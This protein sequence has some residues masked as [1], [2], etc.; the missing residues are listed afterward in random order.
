MML[1]TLFRRFILATALAASASLAIPSARAADGRN[2]LEKAAIAV[3]RSDAAEADKALA[4]KQI[5]I[6]GS[7]D[8]VPDLAALLDNEKLHSWARTGLEAIP[9]PEADGALRAAAATLSGNLLVGTINSLGVR[10]DAGALAVLTQRLA[11]R[12]PDV[13]SAAAV[14]LGHLGT[15]P[16]ISA[17]KSALPRANGAVQS[18]IAEGCIYAAEELL[19]AGKA[20]DA[21]ALYDEV[22]KAP[23]PAQRKLE[24]TR[25]AILA[26]GD[27]AAPLLIEQLQ[28]PEQSLFRLGLTTAREVKQGKCDAALVAEL[29]KLPAARAALLL[30]ALADR[31][32]PAAVEALIAAAGKGG[33]ETRLA[34][35]ESL[36]A[37]GNAKALAVL[38]EGAVD[39]DADLARAATASISSLSGTE[40]NSEIKKRLSNAQGKLLPML[41]ELVGQ[42]RIDAIPP[43]LAAVDSQ[44]PA[45]R[46][47]ALA[48]LGNIVDVER[49]PVLVS[50]VVKPRDETD[51]ANAKKALLTAAIRMPDRE[52]C[53]SAVVAPLS[54]A[55]AAAKQVLLETLGAV[56]GTKA[57]T[58]VAAA[59]KNGDDAQKDVASRLLGEW[60]T[61]DAAPVLLDLSKTLAEDKYRGRAIRGFIRIARQFKLEQSER[62]KMALE[63]FSAAKT[64][65]EKKLVLEVARRYPD[66]EMLKLAA[67]A[68]AD[69]E[70]K[71]ESRIAAAA[72][73]KKLPEESAEAYALAKGLGLEKVS[74]EIVKATYGSGD[75]QKDVTD[76]V[77]KN[78]GSLPLIYIAGNGFN[79]VF[80]GDPAPSAVKHLVIQYTIDGQPGEA[81]IEENGTIVLATP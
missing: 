15:L 56:G 21:A 51:A 72:I 76:V 52:A 70:L 16:A 32:S 53:S 81:M 14:A 8:A 18:A 27:D 34:A 57:L 25:G 59:A 17:L 74:L 33:K 3:L 60:M 43:A 29:P 6:F 46:A 69:D 26:R 80:G 67:K 64:A 22:R 12:D 13:A 62:A 5:A 23:V 78:A 73:V 66:M 37:A 10:K 1:N 58:A 31:K 35:L 48:A 11:D 45:T 77:R 49:L 47:A 2:D 7:A 65:A 54:S 75:R 71:P 19:A 4:C 24:A 20:S 40:V 63:A 44:D 42:R 68:G 79:A 55:P 30:R 38:L 9:G 36:G 39:A 28:S 50:Q 61:P 41:L